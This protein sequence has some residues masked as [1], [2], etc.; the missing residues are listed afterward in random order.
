LEFWFLLRE[1]KNG[2]GLKTK[3]HQTLVD[4]LRDGPLPLPQILKRLNL[5]HVTQLDTGYLFQ[6]E[7]IAKAGLTPTDLLHVEDRFAPWD[8]KAASLASDFLCRLHSSDSDRLRQKVWAIM[9]ET[10]V[11]AIVSF[12]T[13]QTPF[14]TQKQH[15][16]FGDWFLQN[17]LYDTHPNFETRIRLRQ[18]LVGIGAPA[19][20]FLKPVAEALHTDLILPDFHEVA[21]AVGAVAGSIMACEDV[22]VFPRVSPKGYGTTGFYAQTSDGRQLF[23]A[24]HEALSY[25]R[26]F[27]RDRALDEAS[28]S[29]ADNPQV[30]IDEQSEGFD[31]YRIQARAVGN[32]RLTV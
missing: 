3:H 21:N 15:A 11:G 19:A 10:I 16:A 28:R 22:L 8:T 4:I 17:S 1:P 26:T 2:N 31:T 20:I 30:I 29:G 6:Q 32:P 5:L 12:L 23:E 14:P 13:G 24:A 25:A 27:S 18:P 9:T 7:I